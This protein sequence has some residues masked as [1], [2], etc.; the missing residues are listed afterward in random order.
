MKNTNETILI[1]EFWY[2]WSAKKNQWI[3]EIY[4]T[5]ENN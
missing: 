2:F 3:K 5:S 1:G 4:K